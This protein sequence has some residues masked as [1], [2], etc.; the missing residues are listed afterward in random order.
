MI[1]NDVFERFVAESPVSVMARALFENALPADALDQLFDTHADKQST[2]EL[3][4][5][6]VVDVLSL[7]VCNAQPSL[8]AAIRK[9]ADTLPVTR[10]SVYAKIANLEPALGHALVRYTADRLGAVLAELAPPAPPAVPGCR[11][12]VIDGNHL[13]A[14]EHRIKPL[15]STRAGALPGQALV[16]FDPALGLVTDVICRECGHAQE[17]ALTPEFLGLVRANDVW[18][19]TA[20]SPPRDSCRASSPGAGTS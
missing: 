5:S 19:P 10:K 6:Q 17:R 13:P 12:R 4:F 20:T 3:L 14:S 1:L 11:P 15:R 9:R 2:R 7:V 18:L 16:A 8:F